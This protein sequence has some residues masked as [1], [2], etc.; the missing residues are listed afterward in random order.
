MKRTLILI[1]TVS[2]S[3]ALTSVSFASPFQDRGQMVFGNLPE[4]YIN[5]TDNQSF[6]VSYSYIFVTDNNGTYFFPFSSAKWDFKKISDYRN[7]YSATIHSS[8]NTFGMINITNQNVSGQMPYLAYEKTANVSIITNRTSEVLP[9]ST[10]TV[11][12]LEITIKISSSSFQSPGEISLYQFLGVRSIFNSNLSFN[13][14]KFENFSQN[15]SHYLNITGEKNVNAYYWWG[16]NYTMN[17]EQKVFSS[18]ENKVTPSRLFTAVVFTYQFSVSNSTKS[19]D[20]VQDPFFSVP[21]F[22]ILNHTVIY[23]AINS[24]REFLYEH[25]EFLGAGLATGFV[26]LGASYGYY[27]KKRI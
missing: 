11:S 3:L 23:K 18:N 26:L 2:L 12:A 15:K 8:M 21:T 5:T 22:N 6:N 25:I 4:V 17:G 16:N 1:L 9:N 13:H 10:K 24:I 20:I 14:Y 19:F 7:E 27:R